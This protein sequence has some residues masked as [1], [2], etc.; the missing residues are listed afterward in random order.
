[1]QLFKQLLEIRSGT[2]NGQLIFHDD[3]DESLSH[4]EGIALATRTYSKPDQQLIVINCDYA[5]GNDDVVFV[6]VEGPIAS[7]IALYHEIEPTNNHHSYVFE[8]YNQRIVDC[9]E[10]MKYF[11]GIK[12]I[13]INLNQCTLKKN[14]GALLRDQQSMSVETN[15]CNF[16]NSN[17]S[18]A[19]SRIFDSLRYGTID[20]F[21]FQQ[22]MIDAGFEEYL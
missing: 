7:L 14:L 5:D 15:Y 1:M 22:R 9:E 6:E 18:D 11:D 10:F 16:G 21:D 17:V 12:N 8:F 13:Y 20:E 3:V 4:E 19:I 2:Y